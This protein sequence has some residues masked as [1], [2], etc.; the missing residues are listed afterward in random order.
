MLLVRLTNSQCNSFQYILRACVCRD[1]KMR[2]KYKLYSFFVCLFLLNF[3]GFREKNK[4]KVH[5]PA[6]SVMSNSVIPW[7]V[8]HKLPLSVELSRQEFW[9]GLPFP[10]SEDHLDPGIILVSLSSPALA[11]RFF[12]AAPLRSL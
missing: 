12:T 9:I 2:K 1:L 8:A 3:V 10:A 4:I 6:R 5:M 11:G 7:T